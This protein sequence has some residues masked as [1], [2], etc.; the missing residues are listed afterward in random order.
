MKKYILGLITG[1][2]VAG[3]VGVLAY[4]I[5][6]D[7]IGYSPKDSSWKVTNVNDAINDL[8]K[9]GGSSSNKF[10]ELKSGEALAIGSMYECDPGDGVKRNFYV[11]EVRNNEVDLIME[12]NIAKGTM[13][14]YN[15]MKYFSDGA[16]SSIKSSWTNVL[17][18]DLPKAQ[19]IANAVG[20]SSWKAAENNAWWCLE[21]KKQDTTSSP[22]C[23]N[24]TQNTMWLWDYTRECASWKCAHSL[25]SEWAYGYWTR[26]AIVNKEWAWS[27]SRYGVLNRDA[28]SYAA[29]NGVR[30]VI[31][32]S[33]S[34][35]SN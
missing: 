13:T 19:A 15:A 22:Y 10:C 25:D 26:D 14:W 4:T 32:V 12:Q 31:T 27:V 3:S 6:A 24:N 20:N 35:L 30:P 33:K 29:D 21:T 1:L 18:I 28:V 16:G 7:K 8:K 2:V 34:N 5:T 23:Y 9:N 17:N 11:L